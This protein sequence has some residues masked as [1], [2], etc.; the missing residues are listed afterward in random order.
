M[1][2]Q[3]G[4]FNTGTKRNG[5]VVYLYDPVLASSSF[6]DDTVEAALAAGAAP[7]VPPEARGGKAQDERAKDHLT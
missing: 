2:P 6:L 3:K 4:F 5:H 7:Y 1:L